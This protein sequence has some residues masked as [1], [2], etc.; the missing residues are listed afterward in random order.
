MQSK[1]VT[2]FRTF[3]ELVDLVIVIW[4]HEIITVLYT[5]FKMFALD[6]SAYEMLVWFVVVTTVREKSSVFVCLNIHVDTEP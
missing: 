6:S 4:V 2:V 5:H 1:F 3:V